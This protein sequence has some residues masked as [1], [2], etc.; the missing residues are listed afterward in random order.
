MIVGE[1]GGGKIILMNI[2]GGLDYDFM[3]IVSIVG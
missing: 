1:L 2:I 3:G